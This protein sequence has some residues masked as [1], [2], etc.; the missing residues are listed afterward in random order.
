MFV[1]SKDD[2]LVTTKVR[3]IL[4]SRRANKYNFDLDTYIDN[5]IIPY[6]Y[7]TLFISYIRSKVLIFIA[8]NFRLKCLG[9]EKLKV[10]SF[11][12]S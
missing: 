1:H 8:N 11:T 4:R 3:V 12:V 2:Y 6:L 5:I 7:S 9:L 10:I